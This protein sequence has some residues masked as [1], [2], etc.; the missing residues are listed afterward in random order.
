MYD[1]GRR[2]KGTMYARTK[3]QGTLAA[4][5]WRIEPARGPRRFLRDKL[6]ELR[7]TRSELGKVVWPTREQALWLSGAVCAVALSVGL[8]L[9]GL[10]LTSAELFSALLG[11]L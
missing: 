10:D 3:R 1:S 4:L 8:L 11:R 2:T 5:G 7:G 6:F 9:G